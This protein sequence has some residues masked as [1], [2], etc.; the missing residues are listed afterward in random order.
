MN[1]STSNFI[2]PTISPGRFVCFATS[3]ICALFSPLQAAR[4]DSLELVNG[5]LYSGTLVSMTASNFVFQSEIQGLV[6][7]PRSKVAK[8][9]FREAALPKLSSSNSAH[10]FSDRPTQFSLQFTNRS[11]RPANTLARSPNTVVQE[12]RQQG[13][14]PKLVSHVQDQILAKSTPEVSQKFDELLG[15]LISGSVS[16]DDIRSQAKSSL[17]NI[18][19]AKKIMGDDVG[20]VLDGYLVIL[21]NFL[22]ETDTSPPARN[23]ATNTP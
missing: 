17:Q 5:D 9:L 16:L 8:I 22:N 7:L 18:Q 1:K 15:G 13:V 19:E 20:G 11:A 4:G 14:D 21:Q 6:T 2:R 10:S 12:L 3:F 23:S